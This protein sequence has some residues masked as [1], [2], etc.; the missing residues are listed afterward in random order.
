MATQARAQVSF[1]SGAAGYGNSPTW[2]LSGT[3]AYHEYTT[4]CAIDIDGDSTRELVVSLQPTGG[5]PPRLMV[6][7]APTLDSI[8]DYDFVVPGLNAFELDDVGDFNGDGHP[9][10][11]VPA[12]CNAHIFYGGPEIWDSIPDRKLN[13]CPTSIAL[14][15]DMDLEGRP[16]IVVGNSGYAG[17]DGRA[18]IFLGEPPGDT[19]LDYWIGK[20]GLPLH[21]LELIGM[22]V[23]AAG[24]FNGDGAPDIIVSAENGGNAWH[25]DVFVLGIRQINSGVLD[26]DVSSEAADGAFLLTAYPNPTNSSVVIRL[27]NGHRCPSIDIYDILG[28]RIRTLESAGESRGDGSAWTWDGTTELGRG[29]SSGVYFAR[30]RSQIA[31]K[32]VKIVIVR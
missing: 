5:A 11:S 14:A 22:Q 8:S 21:S 18:E 28:R 12:G 19:T 26:P 32:P 29:V 16:D 1:Y 31:H 27:S 4:C 2:V 3:D 25:G 13:T 6:F 7:D 10:L 17:E 23:A 9:D 20:A 30:G 24:D 15:G